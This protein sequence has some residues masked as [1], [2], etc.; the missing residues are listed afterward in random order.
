M[1]AHS[2]ASTAKVAIEHFTQTA[3]RPLDQQSHSAKVFSRYRSQHRCIISISHS[4]RAISGAPGPCVWSEVPA[5]Y[6]SGLVSALLCCSSTSASTPFSKAVLPNLQNGVRQDL[7]NYR[8]KASVTSSYCCCKLLRLTYDTLQVKVANGSVLVRPLTH[9]WVHDCGGLL[10]G[11][12]ADAMGY[13]PM[14]R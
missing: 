8:H 6:A 9:A 10:T 4:D 13:V 5:F 12:F 2:T 14:Y 7:L 3:H 1:R 11:A